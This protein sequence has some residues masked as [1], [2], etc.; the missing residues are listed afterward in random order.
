MVVFHDQKPFFGRVLS[1]ATTHLLLLHINGSLTSA[2]E[3]SS[4]WQGAEEVTSPKKL[5]LYSSSCQAAGWSKECAGRGRA[6]PFLPG[7]LNFSG[8]EDR[9]TRAPAFLQLITGGQTLTS[10]PLSHR[11]TLRTSSASSTPPRPLALARPWRQGL[12][13]AGG[14]VEGRQQ[15]GGR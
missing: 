11:P 12:T 6:A 3:S 13:L 4:G 7:S 15:L 8:R 1:S 10:K 2:G 14:C 9:P 5:N